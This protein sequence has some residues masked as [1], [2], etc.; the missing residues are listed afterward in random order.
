MYDVDWKQTGKN[1]RAARK[2]ARL[3]QIEAQE[4]AAWG[5]N[6]VCAFEAGRVHPRTDNLMRLCA[7][8]GCKIDDVLAIIEVERL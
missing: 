5:A 8:V 3:T 4:L 1:F 2:K 6:T 7:A